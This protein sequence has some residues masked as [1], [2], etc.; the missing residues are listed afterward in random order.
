MLLSEV[1]DNQG[2]G[3]NCDL[4]VSK[5]LLGLLVFNRL[6]RVHQD[7]QQNNKGMNEIEKK[8]TNNIDEV[9]N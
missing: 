1:C 5:D 7:R 6:S 3:M 8:Y 2:M 9:N 4:N